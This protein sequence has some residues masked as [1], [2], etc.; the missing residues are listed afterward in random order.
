MV[1]DYN[2]IPILIKEHSAIPIM[3]VDYLCK[4]SLFKIWLFNV[5]T[6]MN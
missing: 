2:I 4:Y 6:P 3:D 5:G 1:F